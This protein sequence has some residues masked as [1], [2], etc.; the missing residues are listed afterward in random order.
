MRALV[1]SIWGWCTTKGESRVQVLVSP[2]R[3]DLSYKGMIG[4]IGELDCS[5]AYIRLREPGKSENKAECSFRA[6]L[7]AFRKLDSNEKENHSS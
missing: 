1:I 7:L 4:A 6:N 5:S 3:G 2:N